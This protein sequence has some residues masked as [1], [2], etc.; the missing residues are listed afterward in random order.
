MSCTKIIY[1]NLVNN[2]INVLFMKCSFLSYLILFCG[3]FFMMNFVH[4]Q[5]TYIIEPDGSGDFPTIQDGI[6][7]CIDGDTIALADG[8]FTGPNND[9]LK[10]FGKAITIKSLSGNAEDCIIKP[11][12]Q[13]DTVKRG[14][15]L[16]NFE[17]SNTVIR[18]LTI[19]QAVALQH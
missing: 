4:C 14:F 2:N 3:F 12:H 17:S 10:V 13:D 1:I 7:A 9:N 5:T 19:R 18:D 11:G 6:Y 15:C 8:I 16:D